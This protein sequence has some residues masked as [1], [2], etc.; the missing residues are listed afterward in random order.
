MV[1]NGNPKNN[2]VNEPDKE[3]LDFQILVATQTLERNI[4]FINNCDNKASIIL[5]VVG[6]LFAI[7]LTNDGVKNIEGI[8]RQILLWGNFFTY[9][10]I[11][12]FIVS[13]LT[14]IVGLILLGTVLIGRTSEK[15]KGMPKTSSNI[16]FNG[17]NECKSSLEYQ[18][19]FKSMDRGRVL[20]ELLSQIYINADI[21]SQKYKRFNLGYKITI[22]GFSAL[23][24]LLTVGYFSQF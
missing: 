21:A 13:V 6:V 2:E 18:N 15:A 22:I 4:G 24:I 19:D 14:I 23:I 20:D 7:L 9:A 5:S 17:I 10:L 16:F 11:I 8:F 1:K 3:E 12:L